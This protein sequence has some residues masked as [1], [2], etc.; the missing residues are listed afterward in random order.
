[1]EEYFTNGG[2]LPAIDI[3]RLISSQKNKKTH[4]KSEKKNSFTSEQ[5]TKQK[6]SRE[7]P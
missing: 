2:T 7:E 3:D 4:K 1:M 5:Q 6:T